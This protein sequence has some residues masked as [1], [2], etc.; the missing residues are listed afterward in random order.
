MVASPGAEASEY[1]VNLARPFICRMLL[2]QQSYIRFVS[3]N[4]LGPLPEY[5]I[6]VPSGGRRIVC[7]DQCPRSN[8]NRRSP[9]PTVGS[10]ASSNCHTSRS[11]NRTR[12]SRRTSNTVESRVASS[13]SWPWASGRINNGTRIVLRNSARDLGGV[14]VLR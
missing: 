10:P 1:T 6:L 4:G 2:V 13:A 5:R 14:S 9:P 11:M 7:H 12:P 3:R 8:S